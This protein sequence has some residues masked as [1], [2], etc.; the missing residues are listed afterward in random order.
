MFFLIALAQLGCCWWDVEFLKGPL[1]FIFYI[2][3]L[4]SVTAL[5]LIMFADDTIIFATGHSPSVLT[6][7]LNDDRKL[8]A[9]DFLQTS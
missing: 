9:I 5:K 1:L 4:Q 8:K 2:N 7:T 6:D 3:D